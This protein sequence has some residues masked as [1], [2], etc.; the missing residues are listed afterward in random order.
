M[1]DLE[2]NDILAKELGLEF[3]KRNLEE[4]FNVYFFN[5][6]AVVL[7]DEIRC[8]LA[9][10]LKIMMGYRDLCREMVQ[11]DE[12]CQELDRLEKLDNVSMPDEMKSCLDHLFGK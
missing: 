5:D 2:A 9:S 7:P 3:H 12:V 8:H 4:R 6:E 1:T 10:Y 11:Q